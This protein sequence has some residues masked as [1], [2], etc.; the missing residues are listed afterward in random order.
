MACRLASN[1]SKNAEKSDFLNSMIASSN[2]V[3]QREGWRGRFPYVRF[4]YFAGY[5][6]AGFYGADVVFKRVVG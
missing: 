5:G 3:H 4:A 2:V 1:Q 6:F